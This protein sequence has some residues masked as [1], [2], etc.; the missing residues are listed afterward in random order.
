MKR[1]LLHENHNRQDKAQKG[2]Y[3]EDFRDKPPTYTKM[4]DADRL[5][6]RRE[7]REREIKRVR[8]M[9]FFVGGL[10]V[11]FGWPLSHFAT[12]NGLPGDAPATKA[13][14]DHIKTAAESDMLKLT[15]AINQGSVQ[16]LK[17][18]NLGGGTSTLS[19]ILV[20]VWT[21]PDGLRCDEIR[22]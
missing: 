4:P 11:K 21:P 16:G 9:R 13:A 10:Q 19:S 1:Q 18:R 3:R 6:R 7:A 15:A 17:V 20:A 2:D 14:F 5:R 12:V 8:S 22:K